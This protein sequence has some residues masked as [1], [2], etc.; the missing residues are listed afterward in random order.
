MFGWAMGMSPIMLRLC[1]P[2]DVSCTPSFSGLSVELASTSRM[3]AIASGGMGT[4]R[5]RMPNASA[6]ACI[7]CILSREPASAR[8]LAQPLQWVSQARL[9]WRL[10]TS[11]LPPRAA[12][13]R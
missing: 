1:V 6:S 3:N 8:P 12:A 11:P 4:S 7:S 10:E 13:G 2:M 9:V 5:R